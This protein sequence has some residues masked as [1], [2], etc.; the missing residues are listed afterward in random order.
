M[1]FNNETF[2]SE[3]FYQQFLNFEK[4]MNEKQQKSTVSPKA[5]LPKKG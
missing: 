3:L 4:K 5:E 1:V 2:L